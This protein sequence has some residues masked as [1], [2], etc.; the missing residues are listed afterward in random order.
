MDAVGFQKAALMG[1]S[2]GGPAAMAF[3]ATRPERTRAL[4][5]IGTCA[6]TGVEWTQL[7]SD[8][9]DIR[10][11]VLRELG[12]KYTPSVEQF[13]RAQNRPQRPLGVG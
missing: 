8:P 9:A 13:A 2:E 6:Y 1:I 5:L 3:A 12:E 7:E 10:D 4:V 11:S